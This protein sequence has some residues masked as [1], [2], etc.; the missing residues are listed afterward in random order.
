M[1]IRQLFSSDSESSSSKGSKPSPTE[2]IELPP[3]MAEM[4]AT[5]L[6]EFLKQSI[7]HKKASF[8]GT[9]SKEVRKHSTPEII[10]NAV[11]ENLVRRFYSNLLHS[12]YDDSTV[13]CTIVDDVEFFLDEKLLCTI[14][15]VQP[16]G[17]RIYC[18]KRWDKK[19][20]S[21]SF[22][23]AMEVI[24]DSVVDPKW[25]KKPNLKNANQ[26]TKTMARIVK[27]TIMPKLGNLSGPSY[28]ELNVL[29]HLKMEPSL[30]LPYLILNHMVESAKTTRNQFVLSYGMILTL[31]F[32]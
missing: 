30:N 5:E 6:L 13:I 17:K 16:K 14:L 18:S 11:Y 3:E 2:N 9:K 29:Y 31:I 10:E 26:T 24:A 23:Q 32:K 27:M 25:L 7:A 8:S 20:T 4:I 28:N 22:A 19:S 12:S 21:V 1:K 15:G